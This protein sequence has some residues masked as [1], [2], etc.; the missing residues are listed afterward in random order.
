[1]LYLVNENIKKWTQRHGS[2]DQVSNQLIVLYGERLP[3]SYSEPTKDNAQN[4]F[5]L[6]QK[7]GSDE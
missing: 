5:I 6:M 7:N 3:Q 4:A 2:W 1:M